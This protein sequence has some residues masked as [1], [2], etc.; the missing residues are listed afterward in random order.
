MDSHIANVGYIFFNLLRS[1]CFKFD[2]ESPTNH[3]GRKS[4]FLQSL[5]AKITGLDAIPES[6]ARHSLYKTQLEDYIRM[7]NFLHF[8]ETKYTVIFPSGHGTGWKLQV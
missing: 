1:K 8:I 5:K 3:R 2:L 4:L 6:L 7:V